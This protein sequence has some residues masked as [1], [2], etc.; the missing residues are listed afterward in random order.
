MAVLS[1]AQ[2]AIR[3]VGRPQTFRRCA[4]VQSIVVVAQS[5]PAGLFAHGGDEVSVCFAHLIGWTEEARGI[6]PG[7]IS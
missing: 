6:V 3:A 5:T 7:L 1:Q 2:D 4:A